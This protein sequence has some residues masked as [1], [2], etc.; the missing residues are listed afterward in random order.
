[1]VDDYGSIPTPVNHEGQTRRS[2]HWRCSLCVE[3]SRTDGS[4]CHA[5]CSFPPC[6]CAALPMSQPKPAPTRPQVTAHYKEPF[7]RHPST[8]RSVNT[9]RRKTSFRPSIRGTH[10]WL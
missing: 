5:L 1:M 2:T 7:P 4:V 3:S 10:T 8:R 6:V 9:H